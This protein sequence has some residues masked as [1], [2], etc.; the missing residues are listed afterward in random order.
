M[1]NMNA[2]K[3]PIWI[4]GGGISGL[5]TAW[6]LHQRGVPVRLLESRG[7]AGGNLRTSHQQGYLIEHGPNSTLQKVGD[8]EDALGRLITALE[9]DPQR[10]PANA[11]AS[12]RYIQ[13]NRRLLPL[14]TSPL[15]FLR[16]SVF[17]W[18]AKLRL[19]AEPWI[20]KGMDE[21]TI[22]TFVR[23]RL[24]QEFLD[25]AVDPFISGVYAGNPSLLSVQAAVPKIYALERDHGSLIRGALA[26]GKARKAAGMP[27]GSLIS[28]T[29]GME[30]LPR[31]IANRLPPGSLRTDT[32]V[33]AIAPEGQGQWRVS[34]QQKGLS[35]QELGRGVILA[36]PAPVAADLLQ[37]LDAT[38]HR[39]LQAIPYA[40]IAAIALG[41][42]R[43]QVTHPLDGFGFLVPRREHLNLLGTLFS[44]TLFPGRAEAGKVLLTNFIGGAGNTEVLEQNDTDLVALVARELANCLGIS[45]APEFI[46]LTRYTQAIPQYTLGH[47]ER[48]GELDR[49]LAQYPGLSCRANWRDGISVADCV[50]QAEKTAQRLTEKLT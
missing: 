16:T 47:L 43:E 38:A 22:A 33:V 35:G 31:A 13:R 45:G 14:P 49:I 27:Q 48:I 17:S 29:D 18:P 46:H 37:P 9:L 42:L 28:F 5:A 19:L 40:P 34:W 6:F 50:R 3:L 39:L 15:A 4:I 8:P 1:T 26:T 23:R 30:T 25:Y 44:S 7:Q 10:L 2:S 32:R 11:K 20:G 41:Y 21:E 36:V 12:R 24:G